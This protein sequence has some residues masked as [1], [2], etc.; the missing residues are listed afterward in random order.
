MGLVLFCGYCGGDWLV[1]VGFCFLRLV[2]LLFAFCDC[3]IVLWVDAAVCW[4]GNCWCCCIV[5]IAI[6]DF[7]VWIL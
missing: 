4:F 2:Y 7:C 5:L 3:W 6:V 1:W